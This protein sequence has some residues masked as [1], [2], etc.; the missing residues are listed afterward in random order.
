MLFVFDQKHPENQCGY[1]HLINFDSDFDHLNPLNIFQFV[2]KPLPE[3][4]AYLSDK[5]CVRLPVI[6]AEL[7]KSDHPSL[8]HDFDKIHLIFFAAQL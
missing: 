3:L 5:H 4:N 2:L 7:L 1:W 8:H 6:P